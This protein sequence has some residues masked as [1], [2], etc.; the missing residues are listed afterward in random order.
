MGFLESGRRQ[1]ADTQ[2]RNISRGAISRHSEVETYPCET[3]KTR[4]VETKRMGLE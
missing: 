2:A 3:N 1:H 4:S